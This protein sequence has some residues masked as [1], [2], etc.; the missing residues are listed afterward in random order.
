[1]KFRGPDKKSMAAAMGVGLVRAYQWTIRPIIG[2]RCRYLPHCSDYSI[3]A[4]E[5]YGFMT[6]SWLAAKRLS[7][8]HPWCRGGLDPV[9]DRSTASSSVAPSSQHSFTK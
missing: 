5:R 2:P 4:I 6:G 1:M 9:P 3:E 7:R 8:C